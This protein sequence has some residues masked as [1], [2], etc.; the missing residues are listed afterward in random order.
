MSYTIHLR[1]ESA[2]D[3]L[4]IVE[5]AVWHYANGGTWSSRENHHHLTMGGS[6]TS[7]LLR[8]QTTSGELFSVVVGVH[9]Y[10][11]WGDVQVNLAP[12]DTGVKLNPE[13]YAGGRLSAEAH[14]EIARTTSGGHTVSLTFDAVEGHQISAVLHY[15]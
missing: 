15:H 3:D 4:S 7:G 2:N 9:N 12:G 11:P 5:Q 14:K 8:I 13:Y 1:I 6:G 10:A